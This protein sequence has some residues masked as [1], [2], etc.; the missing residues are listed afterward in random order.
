LPSQ[1]LLSTFSLPVTEAQVITQS[2]KP[3]TEFG[4]TLLLTQ[5]LAKGEEAAFQEFHR[6]YFDRL[7]HFLI[8]VAQG[9]EDDAQEALQE[10]FLRVL[11]YAH[12]FET[13]E[14]FWC[15][16]KKVARSTAQD[17]GR[18]HQRYLSVLKK[19]A[20]GWG[21]PRR[22]DAGDED[23]RLRSLVAESLEELNAQDRILIEGKYLQEASVREL[24]AK[25]GLTDKAVESRLLR[26]RRRLRERM[27]QKLGSDEH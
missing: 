2:F 7:Y 13:E 18:K 6:L 19:F 21:G 14:A 11:R 27:L 17:G 10:T 8:V 4:S 15:W 5:Q 23:E 20:T 16:L 9:Q 12:P 24:S 22:Q 26:L 3:T 25:T 1:T